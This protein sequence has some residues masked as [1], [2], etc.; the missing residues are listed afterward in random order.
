MRCA[1]GS[2][3]A[4]TDWLPSLGNNRLRLSQAAGAKTVSIRITRELFDQEEKERIQL[5]FYTA[6]FAES[7]PRRLG[8]DIASTVLA[9]DK[10]MARRVWNSYRSTWNAVDKATAP[11]WQTK[12]DRIAVLRGAPAIAR[13]AGAVIKWDVWLAKRRQEVM[14]RRKVA[15]SL[16]LREGAIKWGI[17]KV[18]Q[19]EKELENIERIQAQGAP[20]R[21]LPRRARGAGNT[22]AE[23]DSR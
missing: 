4:A 19:L 21:A 2:F 12:K 5:H 6:L 11:D 7:I 13:R 8:A 10:L 20:T 3:R 23:K 1:A 14:A 18:R 22:S 9:R 15:A 17:Q 16:A